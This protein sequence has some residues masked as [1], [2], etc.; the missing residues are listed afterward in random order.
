MWSAGSTARHSVSGT[1]C[2]PART[3]L[4]HAQAPPLSRQCTTDGARASQGALFLRVGVLHPLVRAAQVPW[5][6][7]RARTG[8]SRKTTCRPHYSHTT[9][10]RGLFSSQVLFIH[11]IT[12]QPPP[13]P[14]SGGSQ[15]SGKA[16]VFPASP[17]AVSAQSYLLSTPRRASI[18]RA[19]RWIPRAAWWSLRTRTERKRAVSGRTRRLHS[20]KSTEGAP[21]APLWRAGGAGG[22]GGRECLIV[23]AA[24]MDCPPT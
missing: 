1:A 18:P 19:T 12:Q 13:P 11:F 22:R 2:P 10:Y 14:P 16:P 24:N 21:V 6:N 5:L 23:H 7:E 4:Q 8:N 17:S 20:T 15:L 3:Q 9:D